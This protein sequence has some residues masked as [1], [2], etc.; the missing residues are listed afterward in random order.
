MAWWRYATL[1]ANPT[2][3]TPGAKAR[4]KDPR[5]WRVLLILLLPP[6]LLFSS[7]ALPTA[8]HASPSPPLSWRQLC[9]APPAPPLPSAPNHSSSR[10]GYTSPSLLAR[11]RTASSASYAEEY[12]RARASGLSLD[13]FLDVAEQLGPPRLETAHLLGI[14]AARTDGGAAAILRLSR[15]GPPFD[16]AVHGAAWAPLLA[17]L[18]QRGED[19]LLAG[20]GAAAALPPPSPAA[21]RLLAAHAEQLLLSLRRADATAAGLA[22]HGVGHALILAA[23]AATRAAA[24]GGGARRALRAALGACAALGDALAL[25]GGVW[26]RGMRWGCAHG[27]YMVLSDARRWASPALLGEPPPRDG[28]LAARAARGEPLVGVCEAE[29]GGGGEGGSVCVEVAAAPRAEPSACFAWLVLARARGAPTRLADCG[30]APPCAFGLGVGSRGGAVACE[31][32]AGAAARL[33]CAAGVA[34]G[35]AMAARAGHGGGGACGRGVGVAPCEMSAALMAGVSGGERA[36]ECFFAVL[37]APPDEPSGGGVEARGGGAEASGGGVEASGGGVE[38]SGGGVE[39]RGGGVEARGG[40]VEAR[41]GGVEGKGGVEARGG[42]VEVSG[43]GVERKG[44]LEARDGGEQARGGEV[45]ARDGD[46]EARGSGAEASGG[47]VPANT[48]VSPSGFQAYEASRAHCVWSAAQPSDSFASAGKPALLVRP[49]WSHEYMGAATDL[50]LSPPAAGRVCALHNRTFIFRLGPIH[51]APGESVLYRL[52]WPF[53]GAERRAAAAAGGY[54]A[55]F[56]GVVDWRGALLAHPPLHIHHATTWRA[57]LPSPPRLAAWWPY[58]AHMDSHFPGGLGDRACRAAEGGAACSFLELP[59]ATR[60]RWFEASE[61]VVDGIVINEG[62]APLSNLSL[63]MAV[64]VAPRGVGGVR[65][66]VQLTFTLQ[67]EPGKAFGVF[68]K[69]RGD[70]IH[71]TS[72][73]MPLGG[74]V[75]AHDFHMHG[76]FLREAWVLRLGAAASLGSLAAHL[77]ATLAA[78]AATP[79]QRVLCVVTPDEEGGALRLPRMRGATAAAPPACADWAFA[80]GE[81]VTI[82]AFLH[83]EGVESA[84]VHVAWLP[85]VSFDDAAVLAAVGE[86]RSDASAQNMAEAEEEQAQREAAEAIGRAKDE[87]NR[88]EAERKARAREELFKREAEA[89]AAAREQSLRAAAMASMGR[90]ASQATRERRRLAEEAH[91]DGAPTQM[92]WLTA[93]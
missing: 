81:E 5:A 6:V 74:R 8:R 43:G 48:M 49:Q 20:G 29:G 16:G 68:V 86:A 45:E 18:R 12:L 58:A 31:G 35:E 63:E 47:G 7:W 55:G 27:A 89:K 88:M 44:G 61:P 11:L 51:L 65:D 59:P 71:F 52:R 21:A 32:E 50:P 80:A 22:A 36:A 82:V 70:S 67:V 76:G 72:W 9:A 25:E 79:R 41:G 84:L 3:S 93:E 54:D 69:P 56:M 2:A 24:G 26:A 1:P 19:A 57:P 85:V 90:S 73:V 83:V 14:L 13:Q 40:G 53:G 77:R 60:L 10:L 42:E 15:R 28:S 17:A 38:A 39:A 30:G 64:R 75:E 34:F 66:A 92:G 62:A 46:A 91:L 87:A 4:P 23:L 37:D 33:A 78:S